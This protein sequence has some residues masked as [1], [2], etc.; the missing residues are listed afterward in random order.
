MTILSRSIGITGIR[1]DAGAGRPVFRWF[2]G[3][4]P[5]VRRLNGLHV[6]AATTGRRLSVR[7]LPGWTWKIEFEGRVIALEIPALQIGLLMRP[8]RLPIFLE[9][10]GSTSIRP[11]RPIQGDLMVDALLDRD[12]TTLRGST[13]LQ[14]IE[15]IKPLWSFPVIAWTFTSGLESIQDAHLEHC[16][17]LGTIRF[18]AATHVCIRYRPVAIAV[19]VACLEW[20]L[21]VPASGL[22]GAAS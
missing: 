8:G 13:Y 21:K 1:A 4:W 11:N 6:A 9:S 14:L 7:G 10:G 16:V 20:C 5:E 2:A 17:C 22:P 15:A 19:S 12:W 18:M 3:Q